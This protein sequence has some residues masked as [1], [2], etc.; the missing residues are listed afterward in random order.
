M[1]PTILRNPHAKEHLYSVADQ[2]G[3]SFRGVLTNYNG[4]NG[5]AT[6][7]LAEPLP[8]DNRKFILTPDINGDPLDPITV[9]LADIYTI[10]RPLYE[11]PPPN[12]RSSRDRSD[13]DDA[14]N[15]SK[16]QGTGGTKRRNYKRK[17]VKRKRTKRTRRAKR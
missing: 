11:P 13:D 14:G 7:L 6:F 3:R 17:S 1:N 4:Q 9:R 10:S 2:Q 8:G 16:R 12:V 5:T 15:Y